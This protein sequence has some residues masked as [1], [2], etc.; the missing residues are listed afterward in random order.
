MSATRTCLLKLRIA[1]NQMTNRKHFHTRAGTGVGVTSGTNGSHM[2]NMTMAVCQA[3][4]RKRPPTTMPSKTFVPLSLSAKQPPAPAPASSKPSRVRFFEPSQS[5]AKCKQH[6][7]TIVHAA[8]L[9]SPA[10]STLQR[11]SMPVSITLT[12][13]CGQPFKADSNFK[14]CLCFFKDHTFCECPLKTPQKEKLTKPS[15]AT[16]SPL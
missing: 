11:C 5:D 4:R 15:T 12:R 9:Q 8:K 10:K 2:K 1:P 3:G 13:V 14:G 16:K 7:K 6:H